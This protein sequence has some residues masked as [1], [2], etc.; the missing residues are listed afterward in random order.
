MD[1]LEF[2]RSYLF[3]VFM[4]DFCLMLAD[5]F[6]DSYQL[7]VLK[8]IVFSYILSVLVYKLYQN[9]TENR[10]ALLLSTFSLF[11]LMPSYFLKTV[12]WTS[13]ENKIQVSL[14][15]PNLTLEDKWSQFGIIKSQGM[16]EKSIEDANDGDLIVFPE[17]ALIYLQR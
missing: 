17:T 9:I 7:L 14:Y 13:A 12:E 1:S 6:I 4:V 5:T 15:Q 16:I 10:S 8:V 11:I 2:L 3:Q